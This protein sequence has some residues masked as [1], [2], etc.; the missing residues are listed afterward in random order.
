MCNLIIR[1]CLGLCTIIDATAV[2][3]YRRCSCADKTCSSFTGCTT[4]TQDEGTCGALNH[5]CDCANMRILAYANTGCTGSPTNVYTSGSC[6]NKTF[7][8]Y[9]D[10]CTA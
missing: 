3:T 5:M 4:F 1:V 9:V 7:C 8:Y 10:S 2:C 6:Y